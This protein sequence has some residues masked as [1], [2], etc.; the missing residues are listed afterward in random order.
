MFRKRHYVALGSVTLAAMLVLNLPAHAAL[1]LKMA[2]G[3]LFLPLFGFVDTAKTLPGKA[4]DIAMPRSQLL[5]ENERLRQE[6]DQLR[7]Q[8]EQGDAA[9]DENKTL[10][11]AVAWKQQQPWNLKLAR[12]VLRD[13][14]NWWRTVQIDKGTEAG[15]HENCPVLTA[16]GLVGRVSVAGTYRSQVVLLGN[17]DC[18]VSARVSNPAHDLGVLMALGPLNNSL[19]NLTYLSSSANLKAGQ[20]VVTS[21]QGG[22]FP[23]GIPIGLVTEEAHPAELGLYAEARVKLSANLGALKEVWVL[24]NPQ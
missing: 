21:G 8:K 9:L 2:V 3:S 18:R 15:I 10:R 5:K 13:P 16:D 4:V 12:V 23:A 22:I 7:V 11:A 24:T 1:R 19:L 17:P 20:Q 14:A 6:N